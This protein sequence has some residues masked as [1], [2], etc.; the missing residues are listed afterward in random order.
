MNLESIC[1]ES[2]ELVREVADFIRTESKKFSLEDVKVKSQNSLVTY[3]DTR[4]E[5]M[6]VEKLSKLVPEAGFITEED[7]EDIKGESLHWVID[8]LDGTTNFIHG[9]PC[10]AVSVALMEEEEVILGIVY[11]INMQECFYTWKDHPAYLNG[12][13]IK[14]SANK[15]LDES[16]L[17][18]GFPYYDYEQLEAYLDTFRHL[19]QNSR[20]IRR[21]G[22][23][24]VD[25]SYV[26]CGRFE[27][28]YEYSLNSWDVA[29]GALLVQ[30]AGGLLNDFSGG[31]DYIFGQEILAS[32]PSIHKEMLE[33]L[34][35]KMKG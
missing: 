28:F 35:E 16:L 27:A 1:T 25:L 33:I 9:L 19:I 6:L 18:T 20:G 23:A 17:A 15:T 13:Q 7:T 8:P 4:A 3:V 10:Y 5:Q 2:R 30:Q 21:L 34:Q 31:T 24:A 32:C 11:E 29:A 12:T 26:A 22:S 14:V